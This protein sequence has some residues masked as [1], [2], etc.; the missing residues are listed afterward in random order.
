[1]TP[2]GWGEH[3]SSEST[4]CHLLIKINCL[5]CNIIVIDIE[6]LAAKACLHSVQTY[7]RVNSWKALETVYSEHTSLLNQDIKIT[8]GPC[9]EPGTLGKKNS[10]PRLRHFE[11]KEREQYW[12][13]EVCRKQNQLSWVNYTRRWTKFKV[14]ARGKMVSATNVSAYRGKAT[15][16]QIS[17]RFWPLHRP[18]LWNRSEQ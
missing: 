1:M 8:P 18:Y 14:K 16:L 12:G 4:T 2:L 10:H 6:V 13:R 3:W 15:H 9:R 17:K 11:V 5:S 7:L